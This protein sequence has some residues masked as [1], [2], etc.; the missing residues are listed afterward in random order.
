MLRVVSSGIA[1]EQTCK[2]MQLSRQRFR[3]ARLLRSTEKI[4]AH[5]RQSDWAAVELL[6]S[7]R[8]LELAAC[9]SD[10]DRDDSPEVVEAL[11]ALVHMNRQIT[12]L[13]EEAK[14]LLTSEQQAAEQRQQAVQSYELNHHTSDTSPGAPGSS[15]SGRNPGW[16][17]S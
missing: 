6:E 4:L 5:A 8:Q 11:A 10:T 16:S 17:N 3:L 2:Q 7:Q 12:G 15:D 1:D 13:V 9:F 14:R